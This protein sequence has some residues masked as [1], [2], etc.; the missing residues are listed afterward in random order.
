[1]S[2]WQFG[3]VRQPSDLHRTPPLLFGTGISPL[4][5]QP[6]RRGSPTAMSYDLRRRSK[7]MADSFHRETLAIWDRIP[8]SVQNGV[9][10]ILKTIFGLY[11]YFVSALVLYLVSTSVYYK[12]KSTAGRWVQDATW[13]PQRTFFVL[14]LVAVPGWAATMTV[15]VV[16]WRVFIP[17]ALRCYKAC[18]GRPST[19]TFLLLPIRS[20]FQDEGPRGEAPIDAEGDATDSDDG[21]TDTLVGHAVPKEQQTARSTSP[22]RIQGWWA[23]LIIYLALSACGLYMWQT[24]EWERDWKYRDSID[25]A[26]KEVSTR[27]NNNGQRVFLVAMFHDNHDVLP[28]WTEQ[29]T[30][31]IYFLGTD[32]VF[33]SIVESYSNDDS[34]DQL[35]RFAQRLTGMGVRHRILV[36]DTSV[37]RD[38]KSD[39]RHIRFLAKTRNLAMQPLLELAARGETFDRIVWSNDVFVHAEAVVE[40]LRTHNGNYDMVCGLDFNFFGQYDLWVIRDRL[41]GFIS[42]LYPF[43][44]EEVG[45]RMVMRDDPAPVFACW[46]GILA[47]TAEPFIP[48]ELRKKNAT[49]LSTA[50]LDPPLPP[51]HPLFPEH[52]TTAPFDMPA[53]VFRDSNGDKECFSSESF[54]MPYDLRRM[55]LKGRMWAVPSVINTYYYDKYIWFKYFLRH[56]VVQWYVRSIENGYRYQLAKTII[57]IAEDVYVWDGGHCHGAHFN[58]TERS[59]RRR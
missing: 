7:A 26:V 40:L 1:M 50:P 43:F 6:S 27:G 11:P 44:F 3:T 14:S 45:M 51:T 19:D 41:G 23:R 35:E 12:W 58:L 38:F 25:S 4:Y 42:G 31:L 30:R 8:S 33:V 48:P 59:I 15:L 22:R 10:A 17:L 37:N 20:T 52:A 55:F 54:L 32:N 29:M 34:A 46:N 36:R 24:R 9:V 47:V 2:K 28:F 5:S 21:E 49:Q 18:R 13:P 39:R 57:G 53:L 56:W 16:V